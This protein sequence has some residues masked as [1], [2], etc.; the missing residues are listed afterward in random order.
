MA[1]E[2]IVNAAT[3]SQPIISIVRRDGHVEAT[4][5]DCDEL[6]D[7]GSA[8]DPRTSRRGVAHRPASEVD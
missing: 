5:G 4:T 2:S 1:I 8:A 7:S 6:S 3:G